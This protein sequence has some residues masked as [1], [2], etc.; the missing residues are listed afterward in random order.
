MTEEKFIRLKD[1]SK[2]TKEQMLTRSKNF[3]EDMNRRRTVRSFSSEVFPLDILENCILTAGTAPSGANKQPWHFAV[4]SNSEMK[5]KI[6]SAAEEEEREFYSTRAPKE[7]LTAL[8][9][10]GTDAN[11]SF[12]ETA[13]YLIAVFAKGYDV[14]PDGTKSKN[15]YAQESVGIACGLLITAIHNAGLVSLTH[16]PSPMNFLNEILDR[17]SNERPYLLIIVGYPEEKV[18]VPDIERKKLSEIADII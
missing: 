3:Y 8:E 14:L 1:Y 6:R 9:P 13:P 7:W 17:P 18:L 11:K 10:F 5:R 16:T 15:Y 12:L 4:I 2:Y